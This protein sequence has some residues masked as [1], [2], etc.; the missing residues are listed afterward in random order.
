MK[1]DSKNNSRPVTT[2][3]DSDKFFDTRKINQK[4]LDIPKKV[5]ISDESR[6]EREFIGGMLFAQ[7]E[8][9]VKLEKELKK[10]R[11]AT[12]IELGNGEKKTVAELNMG[13]FVTSTIQ[14]YLPKFPNSNSFF[15]ES[16]RILG[17]VDRNPNEY[18]KPKQCR[19]FLL[20]YI[21]GR[22]EKE[23]F[24]SLIAL[25]PYVFGQGRSCKLFQHLVAEGQAEVE[26]FRDQAIDMAKKFKDGDYYGFA[27]AMHSTYGVPYQTRLFT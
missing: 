16:F 19:E 5:E 18:I 13:R 23:T 1:K 22:F 7:T 10:A 20:R 2:P 8:G 9:L 11:N 21:Y 25:N 24:L 26:K 14:P 12:V 6:Q 4:N 17:I 27:Q 15:A 3:V